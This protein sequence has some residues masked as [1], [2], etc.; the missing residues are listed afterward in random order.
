MPGLAFLF[1]LSSQDPLMCWGI[2]LQ[3]Q[4]RNELI[5]SCEYSTDTQ[6]YALGITH[7]VFSKYHCLVFSIFF[8]VSIHLG[9]FFIFGPDHQLGYLS[10]LLFMSIPSSS[11]SFLCY[12]RGIQSTKEEVVIEQEVI[13]ETKDIGSLCDWVLDTMQTQGRKN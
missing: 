7:N 10:I 13:S 5:N 11:L 3:V 12:V 4:T 2:H 1:S 8:S 6:V 9:G